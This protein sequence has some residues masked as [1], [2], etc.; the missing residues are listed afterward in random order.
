MALQISGHAKER[1]KERFGGDMLASLRRAIPF[2]AQRG[3][4]RYLKDGDAVFVIKDNNIVAS[5][6]T[7]HQAIAN[8][9]QQGIQMRLSETVQHGICMSNKAVKQAK[10]QAKN[11]KLN[12]TELA[13]HSF[14][15]RVMRCDDDELAK[16]F[17][18][19]RFQ[20]FIGMLIKLRNKVRN[21]N[22]AV[23]RKTKERAEVLQIV[24]EMFGKEAVERVYAEVNRRREKE[25][26]IGT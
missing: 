16:L 15:E 22:Q 17:T 23:V 26:A 4:A 7:H 20:S 10:R 2:G 14:L 3:T 18:E 9:Q 12:A 1:W 11:P 5:V 19:S 25:T 21:V 13:I 6:I 24:G 8:M